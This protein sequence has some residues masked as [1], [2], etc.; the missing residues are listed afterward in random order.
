MTR[1][2]RR[3]APSRS[4]RPGAGCI[5]SGMPVISSPPPAWWPASNMARSAAMVA[6]SFSS[7]MPIGPSIRPPRNCLTTGSSLV[8]STSRGPNMTSSL[9]K[10]MPRLSGTVRA[11]LMLCVTIRNVASVCAFR[12]RKSWLM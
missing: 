8:S 5:C 6:L 2:L 1:S 11:R 3:R 7:D 9:R 4:G 12:S 10:S